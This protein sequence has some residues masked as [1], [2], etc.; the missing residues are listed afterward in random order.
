[1][2]STRR[3]LEAALAAGF[4]RETLAVYADHLL[5]EGDP[6]GELIA[7]DLQIDAHGTTTELVARRASLLSA[8]LGQLRPVDNP[9]LAWV[10]DSFVRGFVDDLAIDASDPNAC[11]RLPAILASPVGPYLRGLTIRGDDAFLDRAVGIA[12]R[13]EHAWL[14][15]LT[16]IKQTWTDAPALADATID[17]AIA[18]MP[19][20]RRL[21]VEGRRVV[22]E[23]PHPAL[24]EL[25]VTG[26]AALGA[27]ATPGTPFAAVDAI[28][29]AFESATTTYWRDEDYAYDDEG[30]PAPAPPG[31]E[32]PPL[33]LDPA[34]LP[35]VRR[36][37][38]SRNEPTD[39]RSSSI[40]I[41]GGGT[42]FDFLGR[43]PMRPQ[44]TH[45]RLPSLRSA[46][47]VLALQ[48]ALLDMP[49]LLEV[50]L[51][52][53]TTLREPELHHERARFTF[54]ASKWPWPSRDRVR[55]GQG[56]RVAIPGARAPDVVTLDTAV[57][58]MEVRWA[59]LPA[60]ARSAWT[61]FWTFLEDL[62]DTREA[63]FPIDVLIY[64]IE[65]CGTSLDEGGWR[66]LREDMRDRRTFGNAHVAIQRCFA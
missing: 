54:A 58:A 20:L 3:D 14:E 46:D 52:R 63:P 49:A 64:A 36:I 42:V 39:A 60:D 35:R 23:F 27:L 15:Q 13:R 33:A 37:D 38:L 24:R 55:S 29:L 12:A 28:D 6:R 66:E 26:A 34:R 62:D 16:L 43:L 41:T 5:A 31:T 25:H 19:R 53:S 2:S 59:G 47:D 65:A 4:A 45:L 51:M 22:D 48:R 21:A 57:R 50:E 8:F 40:A 32:A 10:G 18:A 7:L 17:A 56:L 30:N 11:E 61:M 9:H 1:M 44:L